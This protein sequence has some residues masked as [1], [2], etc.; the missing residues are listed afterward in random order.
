MASKHPYAEAAEYRTDISGWV[1]R[2]C[3]RYAGEDERL[4]RYCCTHQH[5]CECGKLTENNYTICDDCRVKR[6]KERIDNAPREDWNGTTPL[7][8]ESDKFF[9]DSGDLSDYLYDEGL[10]VKD[11]TLY[12]CRPNTVPEFEIHEW[13]HD[14]MPEDLDELPGGWR[15]VEK[16]VNDYLKQHQPLSW[17]STSTIATPESVAKQLGVPVSVPLD[18]LP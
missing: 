15:A 14:E 16:A 2:T 9:F 6:A 5:V 7:C 18:E 4:A 1:C 17:W 13:L 8:T 3:M 10:A 11:V 12:L